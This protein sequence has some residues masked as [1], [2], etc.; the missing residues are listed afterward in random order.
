MSG[1]IAAQPGIEHPP[2]SAV[3]D[4]LAEHRHFGRARL[5]RSETIGFDVRR[6]Q[7]PARSPVPHLMVMAATMTTS[8]A[9]SSTLIDRRMIAA[10][11]PGIRHHASAT[12]GGTSGMSVPTQASSRSAG[13]GSMPCSPDALRMTVMTSGFGRTGAPCSQ[14]RSS[15]R[16]RSGISPS[17]KRS[18]LWSNS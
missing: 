18:R 4:Q 14:S 1:V 13:R 6:A 7:V 2:I 8:R 9:P 17:S 16:F 12:L 5:P 11:P 10:R 15:K 3:R